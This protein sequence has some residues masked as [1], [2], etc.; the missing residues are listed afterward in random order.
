MTMI[1]FS[2]WLAAAAALMP[3]IAIAKRALQSGRDVFAG[4]DLGPGDV[5]AGHYLASGRTAWQVPA[6]RRKSNAA[7]RRGRNRADAYA[8]G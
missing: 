5:D 6:V 7:G 4:C 2:L 3:S 1:H 8:R